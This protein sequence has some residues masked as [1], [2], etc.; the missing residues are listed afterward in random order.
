M[1]AS[2]VSPVHGMSRS[3][4]LVKSFV[5]GKALVA[6][7]RQRRAPAQALAARRA[8]VADGPVPRGGGRGP[9]RAL[10][11]I[12]AGNGERAGLLETIDSIR[13]Y[14]G[15]AV[16]ILVLDDATLDC[17][18]AELRRLRPDV[19]VWTKRWPTCG[20]PRIWPALQRVYAF[21]LDSYDFPVLVK[22]DTD[23]LVTGPLSERAVAHFEA[24]P[25]VGQLGSVWSHADGTPWDNTFEQWML[26]HETR[27][28]P[29]LRRL[30]AQARRHNPEPP[31]KVHGGVNAI[32]RP[33]LEAARSSGWLAWRQPWW[34]NIGE[35]LLVSLV[36]AAA[37]FELGSWGG[38]GEPVISESHLLPYDKERVLA[39]G[40]L[41]VHS[42]KRG[43]DGEAEADLR[44]FFR[45]ARQAVEVG[46]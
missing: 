16:K 15:D 1:R 36:I 21:A 5:L 10:Y 44:E 12:P 37:G 39:E 45:N 31:M 20:P 42:L 7:R 18:P 34:S 13:T 25:R 41:G 27:W 11:V 46:R 4:G 9:L 38:P 32:S 24:H 17:R 6:V 19:D 14:E 22:L 40:K 35:D 43:R 33:A 23:A 2:E 28:I 8:R 30:V 26:E 29:A 3:A